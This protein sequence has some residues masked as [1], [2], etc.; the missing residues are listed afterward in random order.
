MAKNDDSASS[1][2]VL[3][4]LQFPDDLKKGEV[5]V[6]IHGQND[7]KVE[8]FRGISCYTCEEIRLLTRTRF[9]SVT[10]KKLNIVAYSREEIEISGQIQ[11]LFFSD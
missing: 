7:V 2:R 11:G 5:S 4:A 9:L 8:N 10:G 1:S 3:R 6:S